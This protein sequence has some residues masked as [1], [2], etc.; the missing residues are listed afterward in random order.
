M[1]LF[2][3]I[4]KNVIIHEIMWKQVEEEKVFHSRF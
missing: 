1:K 2:I 3:F 4:I